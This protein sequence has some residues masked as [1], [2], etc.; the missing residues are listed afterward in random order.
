MRPTYDENIRHFLGPGEIK[1]EAIGIEYKSTAMQDCIAHTLCEI[2]TMPGDLV[3]VTREIYEHD[4]KEI[5]RHNNKEPVDGNLI[6]I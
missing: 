5:Y 2:E 4:T 1:A 3:I 6:F